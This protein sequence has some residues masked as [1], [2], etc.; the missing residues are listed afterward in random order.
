MVVVEEMKRR[1]FGMQ[2]KAVAGVIEALLMVALVSIVLSV[3]QLVYIPEVMEQRESEHMDLV[4]NQISTLKSMIDLQG[5]TKSTTPISSML[6][7]GSRE[8]P[9]FISIKAFGEVSVKED[10][11][12]KITLLPPPGNLPSGIIP[13]SSKNPMDPKSTTGCVIMLMISA[14]EERSKSREKILPRPI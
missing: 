6:T 13:L 12:Y 4:S 8:L 7:L 9:Y 14:P 2:N 5:V 1:T 11:G 3:V 10:P